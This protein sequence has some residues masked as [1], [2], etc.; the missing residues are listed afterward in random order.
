MADNDAKTKSGLANVFSDDVDQHYIFD[1]VPDDIRRLFYALDFGGKL[2]DLD[3]EVP[4]RGLF[5]GT[6]AQR[7]LYAHW[8][9]GLYADAGHFHSIQV[10]V[11]RC[12]EEPFLSRAQALDRVKGLRPDSKHASFD[13]A[14]GARVW[15]SLKPAMKRY[16]APMVCAILAFPAVRDI[17]TAQL[18][19]R[20]F[21]PMELEPGYGID[22]LK[23]AVS[24]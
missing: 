2:V 22:Q 18:D 14:K 1:D 6:R 12:K 16:Q 7:G 9:I 5:F 24:S 13:A 17:S 10:Q 21:M 19:T 11:F 23:Q 20:V 4:L 3:P 15:E 8:L